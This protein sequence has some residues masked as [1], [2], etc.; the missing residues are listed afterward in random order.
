MVLVY[1]C[2]S[3]A[4]VKPHVYDSILVANKTRFMVLYIAIAQNV[5][6]GAW[7]VETMIQLNNE[8]HF[9]CTIRSTD[10]LN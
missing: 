4:S 1:I 9:I 8:W 2:V 3:T 6:L 10:R 5:V 7:I